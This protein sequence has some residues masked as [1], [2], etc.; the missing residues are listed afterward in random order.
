[1]SMIILNENLQLIKAF[2]QL[3]Q[4]HE[5]DKNLQF[6]TFYDVLSKQNDES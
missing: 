3:F 4:W 5:T 6:D 1:M 2:V